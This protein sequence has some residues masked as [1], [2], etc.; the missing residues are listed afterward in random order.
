MVTIRSEKTELRPLPESPTPHTTRASFRL[1]GW[2][3]PRAAD[4]LLNVALAAVYFLGGS[5]GLQLASL[6][7]SASLVWPPSGIAL[8]ALILGGKRLWPGVFVGALAVNLATTGDLLS[9]IGIAIGNT[10]EA[11][12]GSSIVRR[13][14]VCQVVC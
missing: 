13:I 3:S 4:A 6:H 2:L 14:A 1:P 9:S 10:L 5:L 7:P 12:V 11:I 8:S